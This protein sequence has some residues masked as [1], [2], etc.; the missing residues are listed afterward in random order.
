METKPKRDIVI[1]FS[2]GRTSAFMAVFCKE[3]YKDDNVLVIFANTGK[4]REETLEF[5]DKCDKHF[6]LGVVWLEANVTP[7]KGKGTDY[8]QVT[9]ET[10]SRNGEPFKEVIKKYGLP[11]KLYRHCTRELK[12][13]PL[14][15]YANKYFGHKKWNI[16]LGIRVDEPHRIN[17]NRKNTLYPLADINVDEKFIRTWWD[18]QPFDLQLKDYEGNCDLCFLKSKRKRLTLLSENPNIATWWDEME[19]TYATQYK[20]MFDVRGNTTIQDLIELAQ[21]P[22]E[23][24]Y[25]KHDMRKSQCE[26]D[27]D[28]DVEF[29]CF[30]KN[31]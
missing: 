19:K 9:F 24:V 12:E 28:M 10:A 7:E 2:G 14:R 31:T 16:A 26:F 27:Y 22:F 29:D 15:K 4:E 8:T 23:R 25:D 21:K 17:R 5:V 13:T 11:S 18:K 3:Y 1:S 6:N 20:E 30:C